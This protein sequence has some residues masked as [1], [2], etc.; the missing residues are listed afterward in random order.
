[1]AKV[2]RQG[3]IILEKVDKLPDGYVLTGNKLSMSGETG[4]AH[5]LEGRIFGSTRTS[6][7]GNPTKTITLGD[8]QIHV[9]EEYIV[10]DKAN[11]AMI[12]AEHPALPVET[13]T[14]KIRR[15]RTFTPERPRPVGD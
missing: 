15:L 12:H 2:Y 14:Y 3:D 1:M 10:V 4:N 5:V 7:Q 9:I 11:M 8:R 13:G 6:I